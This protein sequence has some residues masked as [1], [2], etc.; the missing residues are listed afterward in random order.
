MDSI[1]LYG[2]PFS[3][4]VRKVRL[5]LKHKGIDYKLI[6]VMPIGDDQ[7]AEFTANSPLGKIPLLHTGKIWLPDSSVICA[8]LDRVHP[9]RPLLPDDANTAAR[10]LWYQK[11]A[12]D[13]IAG[14]V[15]PHLFA[16]IIVAP[17]IFKREP[18]QTHIDTAV[19]V[20]LP[21]IF[22]YLENE[23]DT[24]YLMGLSLTLAD[25]AVGST[26]VTMQHCDTHCDSGRWPKVAAYIDRLV[27]SELF[28]PIIDEEKQ[29]LSAMSSS[30]ITS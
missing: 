20:E 14:V 29:L 21:Q 27:N 6:P 7:P 28:A 25:I 10:A 4:F 1:T 17:L 2:A 5:A 23:L 12:D 15:G 13:H 8:W 19:N 30:Q 26:F 9:E 18:N 16:E 3:P 24:E 11:Y 22:D